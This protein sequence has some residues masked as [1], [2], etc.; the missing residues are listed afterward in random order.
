MYVAYLVLRQNSALHGG[1]VCKP[2]SS[3]VHSVDV[4][5]TLQC[6]MMFN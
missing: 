6:K 2:L 1:S 5:L 4:D 3:R